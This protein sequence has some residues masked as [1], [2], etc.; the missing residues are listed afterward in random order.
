MARRGVGVETGIEE[1]RRLE[2][3]HH[4]PADRRGLIQNAVNGVGRDGRFDVRRSER[5]VDRAA[6][7]GA[8]EMFNEVGDG[9]RGVER[10]ALL[11]GLSGQPIAVAGEQFTDGVTGDL[12]RGGRGGGVP[13]LVDRRAAGIPVTG[14]VRGHLGLH[15]VRVRRPI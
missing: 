13:R 7:R 2:R 14:I 11:L 12:D 8:G 15:G 9:F 4:R 1:E 5:L 10:F 3:H 6:E